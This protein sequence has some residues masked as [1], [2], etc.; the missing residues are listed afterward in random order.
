MVEASVYLPF[1]SIQNCRDLAGMKTESGLVIKPG[2]LLRSADLAHANVHD[3]LTLEYMNIQDIIDLRTNSEI[4]LHPDRPVPNASHYHASVYH[5]SD[6]EKDTGGAA[7][8]LYDVFEDSLE[9]AQEVYRICVTDP[10]SILAWR[11]FFQVLLAAPA[12]T[13]FHCTQGKDRT[14]VGA[15]L[16]ETALGVNKATILADYLQ[17][18]LYT[19]PEA[20]RDSF[21][22]EEILG[23]HDKMV[24]S[25]ID[26][27][28][29]AHK[30]CF[31]AA[32]NAIEERWGSWMNYLHEA[33]GLTDEDIATLRHKYLETPKQAALALD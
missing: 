2:C 31:E 11:K 7:K 14:G 22:A 9:L 20:T 1:E 24:E 26:T 25:D 29:Y 16:L 6:I 17:T 28:L 15:A 12:G 30:S 21:W 5:I 18:N 10:K 3:L 13:L 8:T 4:L 27:Y 23:S 19:R 32:S 33:I